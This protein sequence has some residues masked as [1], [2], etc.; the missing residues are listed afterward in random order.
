MIGGGG[1]LAGVGHSMTARCGT[2]AQQHNSTKVHQ[3]PANMAECLLPKDTIW[4]WEPSGRERRH[5]CRVRL[6][7][8][9]FHPAMP[10]TTYSDSATTASRGDDGGV[11]GGVGVR[12]SVHA[13]EAASPSTNLSWST[14]WGRDHHEHAGQGTNNDKHKHTLS[15]RKKSTREATAAT[16]KNSTSPRHT[17]T[18]HNAQCKTFT[19]HTAHYTMHHADLHNAQPTCRPRTRS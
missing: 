18:L 9:I 12:L 5:S 2:T 3:S 4:K 15:C 19:M 6:A 13:Q 10:Q 16:T 11:G 7:A 17:Y 14:T 8:S 1:T